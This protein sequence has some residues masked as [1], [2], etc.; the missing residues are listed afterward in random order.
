MWTSAGTMNRDNFDGSIYDS[1]SD[2]QMMG[3]RMYDNETGRF[4]TPDLLWSAFPAD[5]SCV[6]TLSN[7]YQSRDQNTGRTTFVTL[8]NKMDAVVSYLEFS[9]EARIVLTPKFINGPLRFLTGFRV[10]T[11]KE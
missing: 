10:S 4:T 7:T 5:R 3:F 1:E 6:S 9:P 8:E 11:M 2:L